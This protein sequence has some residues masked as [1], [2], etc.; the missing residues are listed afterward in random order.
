MK[1]TKTTKSTK[2]KR[3]EEPQARTQ[4]P[5]TKKSAKP[6][7]Q[8]AGTT[9]GTVDRPASQLPRSGWKD[10]EA[11]KEAQR[12]ARARNDGGANVGA[13]G[14]R[15]E[16][17][18]LYG[19]PMEIPLPK[20]SDKGLRDAAKNILRD[21]KITGDEVDA[22][23]KAANDNGG[24]SK[25]E[26]RDL[27]RL[28]DEVGERFEAGA[29]K[30][31][32]KFV[33]NVADTRPVIRP[34]YGLPVPVPLSID[35]KDKKLNNALKPILG[36]RKIELAEVNKLIDVATANGGLSP[37]ERKDLQRLLDEGS[38][39]MHPAAFARLDM[40]LGNRPMPLPLYGLPVPV[41]FD[42]KLR[43]K[44]LDV[45]VKQMLGDRKMTLAEV[46]QLIKIADDGRGLSKT[47]R[48]DLE[49]L[50]DKAGRFFDPAAKSKLE[51]YIGRLPPIRPLYGLPFAFPGPQ[52]SM[53]GPM[54]MQPGM[55]SASSRPTVELSHAKAFVDTAK[56][57]GGLDSMEKSEM[58]ALLAGGANFTAEAR[59]HIEAYLRTT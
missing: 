52:V 55:L 3:A 36:D 24:L 40:F 59:A 27:K 58:K 56:G 45:A 18:P 22:L 1:I 35:L 6:A 4:A 32:D 54:G 28:M 44:K 20:L 51:N 53:M 23:I 48:K 12:T 42:D 25:T 43:D 2:T 16:I 10:T 41:P 37:T 17:R 15:P 38:A 47:E 11:F 57:N 8:F 7:A 39:F 5:A 19:L 13:I 34:M 29:L 26:K 30:K 33:N 49:A 21:R 31:L 9:Q 50:L 46:D 14:T